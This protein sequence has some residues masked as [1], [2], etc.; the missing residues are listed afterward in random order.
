MEPIPV[1]MLNEIQYCERLFYLMHV[2]GLFEE[3]ADTVEG[4]AQHRRAERHRRTGEMTPPEMK[5]DAPLSLYLGSEELNIIGK[6]D[7]IVVEDK[8]WAPLESKHSSAPD[9]RE[10]FIIGDF[11]L[12]GEAWPNDQ[13]Q[14]CAQGLLLQTNGYCCQY[15]YLYYRGNKKRVRVDFSADL[16]NA[17]KYYITRAKELLN[18]PLPKPLSD[19]KKCFRCSLNYICLPDETN[20]LLGASSNIRKIVPSRADG[21]I[22]YV[23]EPGAHLGKSGETLVITYPDGRKDSLPIKDIVHISLFGNVQCST[24]L[25]HYL[26][27]C[28]I[29]ISY[30]STHGSLWG[31]TTPLI[32]KNINLRQKQFIKFS[33]PEIALRL[34]KWIV[35]AKIANQR[36][37]L[38]RN[39]KASAK[40][41]Q[42]L[43][44]LRNRVLDME[45]IES[46]RGLEGRAGRIYWESFSTML[47]T[48][49]IYNNN[50][51]NGRNRRPPRDPVN[52][53]LSLGYTL[54]A[55]DFMVACSGVGLDPLYGFYH[56]LEPG[57]PAL[58]LDLM[59]PF[60]SLIVDS[61]VIRV[62]NT[63]EIGLKQFYWGQDSCNLKK[64][65]RD[66]F[67]AA[68]ERRM[69]DTITHPLFGY[70][71]SYRRILDLEARILARFLE[72]EFSE[73]HPLVTR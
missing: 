40:V 52:A 14:L 2:Q 5:G 16:I 9:L 57:R 54:L 29:Q 50:I 67:F 15:G 69:Q 46:L 1:R 38:R 51:M 6:L 20:Y 61:I 28:G 34:A 63:G 60:R 59:E 56:Q 4:A 25:I 24:Q 72:G 22:L 58:A 32:T 47:K 36:T 48:K 26:M 62:L 68:Y 33:N 35:Y 41:L 23:S 8:M 21:G 7:A 39:G 42:E 18:G 43:Q 64:N 3:N 11:Q 73:Y 44:E 27:L 13:I 65:G 53:L 12:A 70:K 49:E 17:T 45:N 10:P 66:T 55:R 31:M 71:I 37:L 19:S 30:L